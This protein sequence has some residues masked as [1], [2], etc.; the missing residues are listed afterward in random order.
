MTDPTERHDPARL[1]RLVLRIDSGSTAVMGVVL[2]AASSLLVSPTG[3]PVAFSVGFGLYQLAGATAL[4]F[5]ATR[6]TIPS[7]LG[8]AVVGL[9]IVSGLGCLVVAVAD[10]V[11]LTTFGIVFMIIG[12]MVV[13]VYA[14]LEY[15][16]IRR[17]IESGGGRAFK[18]R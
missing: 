2:I 9:N 13:A 8:W 5:V 17:M 3:I 10:L 12:A 16:G 11:S 15:A 4:F 1:L 6:P 7:V 18:A 14:V